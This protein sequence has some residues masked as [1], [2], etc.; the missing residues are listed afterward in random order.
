MYDTY[1][2][3]SK[4]IKDITSPVNGVI[5]KYEDNILHIK[6]YSMPYIITIEGISSVVNPGKNIT[7]NTLLG[8]TSGEDN[9]LK[10]KIPTAL[11]DTQ[12]LLQRKLNII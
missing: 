2:F 7:T 1:L 6:M 5:V 4:N 12:V 10:I 9:K 8:H 3:N 11:G